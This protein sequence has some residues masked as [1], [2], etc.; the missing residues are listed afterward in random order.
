MRRNHHWK[1][2]NFAFF[3]R[4]I[5]RATRWVLTAAHCVTGLPEGLQLGGVR[6]GEHD[7]SKDPD[8]AHCPPVQN[9]GIAEV[10]FH[11]GYNKP[12]KFMNDIALLKLDREVEYNGHTQPICLPWW[13]DHEDYTSNTFAG[14]DT[15]IKVAGWGAT[16]PSGTNLAQILQF[17]KVPILEQKRCTETYR[18]RGATLED[19]QLCAGG[20]PGKDSCSGDSGSGLMRLVVVPR[21]I[22]GTTIFEE[23]Y[24]L[25]GA[26]SFGPSVC[27]TENVPVVYARVNSYLSW[28]LDEVAK[29]A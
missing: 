26:S 11:P 15:V 23:M 29:H 7:M 4:H 3:F 20:V 1:E 12:R 2:V 10:I 8:C 28:I 6:V 21:T 5:T 27:G 13:D 19:K 24:Q 18:A 22:G 25:I 16:G 14:H 17:S 9:L